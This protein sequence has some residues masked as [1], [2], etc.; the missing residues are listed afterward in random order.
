[1]AAC[2]SKHLVTVMAAAL[3]VLALCVDPRSAAA[4]AG[5][6]GGSIGKQGKSVSGDESPQAPA[7]PPRPAANKRPDSPRVAEP[8]SPCGGIAGVWTWFAG[9]DVVFKPNGTVEALNGL[10]A[11]WHCR[12]GIFTVTWSHGFVDRLTLSSDRARLSGTNN[13]GFGV[14]GTRK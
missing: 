11:R 8:A 7:R 3:A 4:Q 2:T 5:S 6:A 9:G 13:W 10:T 12:D 1:M 14:T